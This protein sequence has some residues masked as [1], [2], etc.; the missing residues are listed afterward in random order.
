MSKLLPHTQPSGIVGGVLKTPPHSRHW[1][2][3]GFELTLADWQPGHLTTVA[4]TPD[5]DIK[6]RLAGAGARRLHLRPYRQ[7]NR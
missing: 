3:M 4:A 5:A 7:R 2:F 6:N 1:D